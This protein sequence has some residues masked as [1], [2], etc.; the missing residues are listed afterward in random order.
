MKPIITALLLALLALL[1]ALP[2]E[3]QIHSIATAI[4]KAGRQ[5]M[6]TQR[7]L[8]AYSMIGINVQIEQAEQQLNGAITLFDKQLQEL[9]SFSTD[10]TVK[11]SLKKVES[12][13]LPFRAILNQP[14]E[15]QRAMQLQEKSDELLRACHRVVLQLE[16]LSG[17]SIG[18]LINIGGRQRMLTQRIAKFYM[19]RAWHFENAEI[20]SEIEQARN[21]F[22]GA[23]SELLSASQNSPMIKRELHTA[24]QEWRLL[25]HGLDRKGAD[26]IPLIVAMTSE[27]L[28]TKMNE[29]TLLYEQLSIERR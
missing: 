19:L 15:R 22:N 13:W 3:A 29:I 8:K 16:D 18:R 27:K 24:E 14:V 9:K 17:N 6:L 23:L 21:E 7:M 12:L 2:A 25:E 10:T 26:L 28:L 4:N 1:T 11:Q 5:R 20:R